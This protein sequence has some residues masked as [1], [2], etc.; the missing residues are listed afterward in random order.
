MAITSLGSLILAMLLTA[1]AVQKNEAPA[2][3]PAISPTI[4]E[5]IASH[6]QV[7]AREG[8]EPLKVNPKLM[9]AAWLHARDMAAHKKLTHEG[10]NGST[11]SQRVEKQG[12]QFRATGENIALG[13]TTVAMV[14][15]SWMNS[16]HHRRNILG[17]FTEIG[18]ARVED[19]EGR[20]YWTVDFGRPIP[21]LDPTGAAQA[22]VDQI[23]QARAKADR[24]A[25]KAAPKLTEAAETAARDM[26]ENDTLRRRDGGSHALEVVRREGYPY[27]E[28][29]QSLASGYPTP[30]KLVQSL[31][32]GENRDTTI[33]GDH[34]DIGVGYARASDGTPYWILL[35]AT[36]RQAP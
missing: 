7:R 16:P 22:V 14:M 17:D 21:K 10:T 8:L 25:L 15:E 9:E 2:G 1:P 24:P 32:N 30:E 19:A 26:A 34:Q 20:P 6:N 5:L 23:N 18:A 36:P 12:Y 29:Q 31:L 27:R 4:Q 33:L 3:S 11:S 13:Q 35:F 28:I